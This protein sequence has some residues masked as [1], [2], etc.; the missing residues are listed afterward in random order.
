MKI[1]LLVTFSLFVCFSGIAQD[2]PIYN[3][4]FLNPYVYNPAF[5]GHNEH[6]VISLSHRRQWMGIEGAPVSS[7][8]SF[9]TTLKG[10]G[11][12]GANI[13]T[14]KR[15][16]LTTSTAELAFG[17][18]VKFGKEQYV[19]FGLAGVG[20]SNSIDL[21]ETQNG[22]AI[23]LENSENG[24]YLD[25]RFGIKIQLNNLNVGFA[26]P[27]LFSKSN[28]NSKK[29]GETTIDPL[30]QYLAMAS[31]KFVI[32]KDNFAFEPH[33][34][35]RALGDGFTQMETTGLFYIKNMLW[36]GANYR[37]DY[38]ATGLLG[39][40]IKETLSVGYAYEMATAVVSGFSNGSHE[41]TINIH[42]ENKKVVEQERIRRP[43]FDIQMDRY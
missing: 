18:K 14:E 19:Q 23:L 8:I 35:Y 15:G 17:Y 28:F 32:S 34:L 10:N 21:E 25:G 20:G 29:A 31:Y 40:K 11:A 24:V 41:I 6:P 38:G 9:H 7:N 16:L 42:L 22:S 2:V 39:I 30:S 33:L 43:R 4:Y 26:L 12:L 3:Q 5:V 36:A 37:M 1:K 27:S 13:Y